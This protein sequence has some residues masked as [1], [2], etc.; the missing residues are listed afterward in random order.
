MA[1]FNS[2][3]RCETKALVVGVE[4]PRHGLDPFGSVLVLEAQHWMPQN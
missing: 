1:I 3:L 4:A 2:S